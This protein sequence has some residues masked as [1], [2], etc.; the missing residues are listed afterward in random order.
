MKKNSMVIIMCV[1]LTVTASVLAACSVDAAETY[2]EPNG[3]VGQATQDER[4]DVVGGE[5][6]DQTGKEVRVSDYEFSDTKSFLHWRYVVRCTDPSNANAA[7]DFVEAACE[8]ENIGYNNYENT[9]EGVAMRNSLYIAA[10]YT[11]FDA[12]AIKTPVDISCTPLVLTGFSAAGIVMDG[13]IPAVYEDTENMYT[14]RTVNA[15]SLAEAIEMVN[16]AYTERGEQAP[17]EIIEMTDDQF[18]DYKN[19]LKRGDM[20][21]SGHHTA[22]VL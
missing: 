16:S 3:K 4:G 20:L 19:N 14:C 12:S 9:P 21:C 22:M 1:V 7:A 15:E 13:Q 5:P 18:R 2:R 17:F 8:N 10:S 6:G 11:K